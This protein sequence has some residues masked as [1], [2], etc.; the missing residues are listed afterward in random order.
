MTTQISKLKRDR[1]KN[2]PESE[3]ETPAALANEVGLTR[4]EKIAALNRWAFVVDR[5]LA[6]GDEGMPT[7]GTEPRDAELMR[8]IELEKQKLEHKH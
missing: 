8:E 5:R 2:D 1:A 7:Y 4:G 3:F 6:S